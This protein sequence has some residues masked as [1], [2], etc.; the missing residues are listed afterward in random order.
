LDGRELLHE[1]QLSSK[2]DGFSPI[3]QPYVYLF[4]NS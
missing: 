1:R 4:T 3:H 2:K